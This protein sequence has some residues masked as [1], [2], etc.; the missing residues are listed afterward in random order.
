[1]KHQSFTTPTMQAHYAR[2]LAQAEAIE[3]A[4]MEYAHC[5]RRTG[6]RH[7]TRALEAELALA[8]AVAELDTPDSLRDQLGIDP[9]PLP[10]EY[11][12][13][14]SPAIFGGYR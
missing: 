4:A 8:E 10:T 6:G 3:T 11:V 13:R 14:I 9:D 5:L 1:M 7:S 2:F 12:E